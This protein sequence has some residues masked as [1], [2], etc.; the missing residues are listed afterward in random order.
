VK[1]TS[2]RTERLAFHVNLRTLR[3]NSALSRIAGGG[4]R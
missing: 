2:N 4:S 1:N 3:T